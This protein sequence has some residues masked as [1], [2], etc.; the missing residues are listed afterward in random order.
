MWTFEFIEPWEL[1]PNYD[2]HC[3][4]PEPT[5]GGV[6]ATVVHTQHWEATVPIDECD[7]ILL[8]VELA[9]I[10]QTPSGNTTIVV[11]PDDMVCQLYY[12]WYFPPASGW[13]TPDTEFCPI[14]PF[15]TIVIPA[16]WGCMP[17]SVET[18]WTT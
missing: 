2:H 4:P 9:L 3:P 8:P 7:E 11:E 13:I 6:F 14:P 16:G 18:Q 1:D 5:E 10:S 17:G 15:V 12:E